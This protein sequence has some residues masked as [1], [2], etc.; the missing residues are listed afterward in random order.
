MYCIYS[1]KKSNLKQYSPKCIEVLLSYSCCS[2]DMF[3]PSQSLCGK[4]FS[5]ILTSI[6]GGTFN[7]HYCKSILVFGTFFIVIIF[8]FI[9]PISSVLPCKANRI[10]STKA[11]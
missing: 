6:L 7:L 4:G 5:E 3:L 8:V 2:T 10:I 1:Q 11:S 9:F